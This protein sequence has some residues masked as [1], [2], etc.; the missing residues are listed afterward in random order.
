MVAATR[1]RPPHRGQAK[2]S[3]ANVWRKRSGHHHLPEAG[4]GDGSSTAAAAADS[5]P[6]AGL[7]DPGALGAARLATPDGLRYRSLRV[8]E[9]RASWRLSV[10]CP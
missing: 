3:L 1:M 5:R 6:A 10:F 4:G 7:H 2:T 8:L 9:D